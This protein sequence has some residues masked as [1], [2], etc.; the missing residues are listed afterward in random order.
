VEA[1]VNR[2]HIAL[3]ERQ[4]GQAKY[5][6]LKLHIAEHPKLPEHLD[7]FCNKH[8]IEEKPVYFEMP[9]FLKPGAKNTFREWT[10]NTAWLCSKRR[11]LLPNKSAKHPQSSH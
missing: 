7:Q 2:T 3:E 9:S 4:I 6:D 5:E 8:L 10:Q 11:S 1:L